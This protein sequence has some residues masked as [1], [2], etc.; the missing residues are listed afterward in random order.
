MTYEEVSKVL[1]DVGFNSGIRNFRKLEFE[2]GRFFVG[3]SETENIT[4][5]Y[6]SVAVKNSQDSLYSVTIEA[7]NQKELKNKINRVIKLLKPKIVAFNKGIEQKLNT[8]KELR[9]IESWS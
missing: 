1:F 7:T 5:I 4:E 8:L 3:F 6:L 2:G 9:K